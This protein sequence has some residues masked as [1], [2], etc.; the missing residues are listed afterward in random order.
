[1]PEDEKGQ[2][3]PESLHCMSNPLARLAHCLLRIMIVDWESVK[4]SEARQEV[5]NWLPCGEVCQLQVA[6]IILSLC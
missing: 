4:M 5:L 6:T 3:M 1:M 2:P